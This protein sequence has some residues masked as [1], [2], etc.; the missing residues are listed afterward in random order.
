MICVFRCCRFLTFPDAVLDPHNG[1]YNGDEEL[2]FG[3]RFCRKEWFRRS[4]RVILRAA[5]G[6]MTIGYALIIVFV[7]YLIDKHDRWRQ[8]RAHGCCG[9]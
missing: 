5:E 9:V 1:I 7:L 8:T 3:S 4:G 2:D 6:L